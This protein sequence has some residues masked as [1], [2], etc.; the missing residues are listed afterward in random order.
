[1]NINYIIIIDI[2]LFL[3]IKRGKNFSDYI[4]IS[5]S[6]YQKKFIDKYINEIRGL[7]IIWLINIKKWK[8]IIY[9]LKIIKIG[10]N[11]WEGAVDNIE[12]HINDNN[13]NNNNNYNRYIPPH[14][15][16]YLMMRLTRA[17][18]PILQHSGM[19]DLNPTQVVIEEP[20]WNQLIF[21]SIYV[22]TAAIMVYLDEKDKQKEEQKEK[23]DENEEGEEE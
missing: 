20:Y 4:W 10:I 19:L 16:W 3:T 14:F 5:I 22:V 6:L 15:R 11:I 8:K 17:L 9:L 1:M 2:I 12:P 13:N 21:W 23:E 7:K 18:L